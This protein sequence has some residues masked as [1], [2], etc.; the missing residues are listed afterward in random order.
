ML[1]VVLKVSK[2]S[3]GAPAYGLGSAQACAGTMSFS[4]ASP[5]PKRTC[6]QDADNADMLTPIPS[7]LGSSEAP[8]KRRRQW[9]LR[10][11]VPDTPPP[12][13]VERIFAATPPPLVETG[14]P[15]LHWRSRVSECCQESMERKKSLMEALLFVSVPMCDFCGKPLRA[16][17]TPPE[18]TEVERN[19]D[20]ELDWIL[21]C[22]DSQPF[23][24][25]A[26]TML[27]MQ[28]LGP[29]VTVSLY[30]EGHDE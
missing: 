2:A 16:L 12:K 1:S 20:P 3:A 30:A 22:L 23:G 28:D 15:P 24:R 18:Q 26:R 21:D 8:A 27:S 6:D 9:K 14:H 19:L 4:A 29:G 25:L 10:D 13:V 11:P 7:E 17:N 5:R